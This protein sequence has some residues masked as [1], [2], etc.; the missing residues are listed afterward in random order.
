MI[1]FRTGLFLFF[2]LVFICSCTR[3]DG[4]DGHVIPNAVKDVDGNKYDAVRIGN[5]VWMKSN[6]RT[7][8]F[9]DGSPISQGGGY[10]NDEETPF[11]YKPTTLQVPTYDEKTYGLYY[12][13]KAVVDERGLCPEGWHVPSGAEWTKLEE[14]VGSKSE[15]IYEG[16]PSNIAKALASNM[17]WEESNIPGSPGHEQEKNNATGFTAI[18]AGIG[19]DWLD[20][21]FEWNNYATIFWASNTWMVTTNY[22]YSF[23]CNSVILIYEDTNLDHDYYGGD[24][25]LSVRC[26]RY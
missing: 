8:H 4:Q 14:Y 22:G 3:D 13:E 20:N 23:K 24:D 6:L 17:G 5:Q 7:T 12:N 9:R 1:N 18:P 11:Y 2:A 26:V 16:K 15:Y 19:A 25:V 21:Y 10:E